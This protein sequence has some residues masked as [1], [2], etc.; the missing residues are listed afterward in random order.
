MNKGVNFK[1]EEV[2][3]LKFREFY[4]WLNFMSLTKR[5]SLV[6]RDIEF[7]RHVKVNSQETRS[8]SLSTVFPVKNGKDVST[9]VS[10]L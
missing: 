1:E 2:I 9:T 4:S 8:Q 7:K 3:I 5:R 10:S 6:H